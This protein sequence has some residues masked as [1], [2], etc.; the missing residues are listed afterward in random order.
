HRGYLEAGADVVSTN[1]FTAT[2]VSQAD[3]GLAEHVEE[4][5]RTGAR[6]ARRVVDE[7]V[8][9]T[10]TPR[11]VAGSVGPTNQTLS[12]SPQVNDPSYRATTFDEIREGYAIAMR[13]LVEGGVDLLLLETIF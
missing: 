10:A 5:N 9:E 3:Y 11:W 1:T 7:V 13:G 12:I 6:I 8:A 2:P 4:I